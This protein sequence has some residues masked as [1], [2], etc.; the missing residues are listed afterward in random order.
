MTDNRTLSQR[1]VETAQA[2]L[3]EG[4]VEGTSGN[5]SVR[6]PDG[7]VLVTPASLA[8][9]TMTADDVV[10]L[11]PSGALVS[12]DRA[13]TSERA[14]HL[15]CLRAH[16]DVGA[17]I[18][19][20]AKYS[21]MFAITHQPIPCVIEEFELYVGGDVPVAP[22]EVTGSDALGEVCAG[23]LADRGAALMANHGL[24]TVGRDLAEAHK[25]AALV[26]RT[27]EIVWGARVLG[28]IVPLP[29]TTRARFAGHY[30]KTRSGR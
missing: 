20:H 6:R 25:V 26:E 12:G 1:L 28:E 4:L 11:D 21:S 8:Y 10:V 17:V 5:L 30:L 7:N 22:Y 15:A 16:P 23:L 13:A 14:L 19:C 29:E 3:R 2:L 9:E 18:H 27:A 24:L